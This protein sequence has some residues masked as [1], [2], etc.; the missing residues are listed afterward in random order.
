VPVIS[1]SR[2]WI[3]SFAESAGYISGQ[4]QIDYH[5]LSRVSPPFPSYLLSVY[6]LI[7]CP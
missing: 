1:S 2:R 3:R 7:I 6:K 5:A 4:K